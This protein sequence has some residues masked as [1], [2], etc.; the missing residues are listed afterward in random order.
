MNDTISSKRKAIEVC[1]NIK[2]TMSRMDDVTV[3]TGEASIRGNGIW[4]AVRVSKQT[5]VN[6]LKKVM[7]KNDLKNEDL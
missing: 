2:A 1:K 7:D 3:T 5:L 6:K 4:T